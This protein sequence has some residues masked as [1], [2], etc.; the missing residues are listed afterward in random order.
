MT[1]FVTPDP[2]SAVTISEGQREAL[3]TQMD[4]FR[5]AGR[6]AVVAG[7]KYVDIDLKITVCV[8]PHAYRGHV[9][10][11]VLEAL[12]GKG[13]VPSF[14]SADNFTFGT[15]LRR[16]QLEA[17]IQHVPGVR[18]VRAIHIRRRG[19]FDWQLFAGLLYPLGDDEVLRLENDRDF[20]ER[21]T[22]QLFME[23]GA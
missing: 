22:V 16:S 17:T 2:K 4:R 18:A 5:Q 8:Q 11:G 10:A 1:A 14:F 20:P 6:E 21:G 9:Q 15:P 19:H 7:P 13:K 3:A 23:G 12:V